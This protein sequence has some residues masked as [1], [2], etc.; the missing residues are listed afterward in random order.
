MSAIHHLIDRVAV[1]PAVHVRFAQPERPACEDALEQSVVV[2]AHVPGSVAI[3]PD[4]GRL[5]QALEV[6]TQTRHR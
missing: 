1:P 4:V 3:D 6:A 2:D 5:D